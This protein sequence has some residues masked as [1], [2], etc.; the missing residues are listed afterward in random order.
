MLQSSVG[1]GWAAV[2]ELG[3]HEINREIGVDSA[4][5]R[6]LVTSQSTSSPIVMNSE[7]SKNG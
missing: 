1:K 3:E 6:L 2:S 7:Y 5:L 4:V